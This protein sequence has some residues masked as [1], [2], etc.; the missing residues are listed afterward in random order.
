[1]VFFP[2]ILFELGDSCQALQYCNLH[3][4]RMPFSLVL[5]LNPK[6]DSHP[7]SKA[8]RQRA[9]KAGDRRALLPVGY[10]AYFMQA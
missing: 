1:V 8:F 4:Y 2:P 3:A 6:R 10:V 7:I 9:E 5:G